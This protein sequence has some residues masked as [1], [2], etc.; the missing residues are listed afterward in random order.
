MGILTRS[1]NAGAPIADRRVATFLLAALVASAG[2]VVAGGAGESEDFQ[3]TG[4][5]L[6]QG[7]N[8]SAGG[9][10]GVEGKS[11]L[12]SAGIGGREFTL[13]SGRLKSTTTTSGCPCQ[14]LFAD[15]FESGDLSAWSASSGS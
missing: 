15:D 13:G 10:F 3:V 9:A 7:D 1:E 5:P 4:Q 12:P 2:L 11:V 8:L 14:G 6:W